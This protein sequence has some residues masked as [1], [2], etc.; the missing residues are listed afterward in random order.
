MK[1]NE[2]ML[3]EE[4]EPLLERE[5]DA[6]LRNSIERQK[7]WRYAREG[8]RKLKKTK[9]AI[10]KRQAA[11]AY[12]GI[13]ND[14]FIDG[15]IDDSV[16]DGVK[17]IPEQFLKVMNEEFRQDELKYVLANKTLDGA[18]DQNGLATRLL[19]YLNAENQHKFIEVINHQ[20]FQRETELEEG[21]ADRQNNR[22]L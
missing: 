11:D 4:E 8:D 10:T 7:M 14:V 22:T 15:D 1:Q 3:E 21:N 19:S 18:K 5:H 2:E 9:S 17:R 12:S 6:L 20:I 13:G 16:L